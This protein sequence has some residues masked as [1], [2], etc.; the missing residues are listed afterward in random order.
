MT[1]SH[2]QHLSARE[3]REIVDALKAKVT[4]KEICAKFNISPRTLTRIA[5]DVSISTG[6]HGGKR[7]FTK[8]VERVRK[9]DFSQPNAIPSVLSKIRGGRA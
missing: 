3:R 6:P 4:P 5:S 9:N 7:I 2:G 1:R 8:P